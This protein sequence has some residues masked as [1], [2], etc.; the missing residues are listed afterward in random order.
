[1]THRAQVHIVVTASA[2]DP[3]PGVLQPAI[4]VALNDYVAK[5]EFPASYVVEVD[6]N[7]TVDILCMTTS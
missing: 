7:V 5:G 6:P 1:M 3:E 4:I 2:K